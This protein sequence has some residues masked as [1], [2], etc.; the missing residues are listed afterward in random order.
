MRAGA[1]AARRADRLERQRD[2][3]GGRAPRQQ[4]LGVV[5]EHD[6]DVAAR[7]L[8]RRAGE[9]DLAAR[10]R[11]RG[12]R[13]RAA[14][15]S[16]RSPRGRRRRRSRRAASRARACRE[17]ADRRRRDRRR[18]NRSAARRRGHRRAPRVARIDVRQRR[19]DMRCRAGARPVRAARAIVEIGEP[20][21]LAQEFF[22]VGESR[23]H[24]SAVA[25]GL[26][27][28]LGMGGERRGEPQAAISAAWKRLVQGRRRRRR[29]RRS[30]GGSSRDIAL[31]LVQGGD[32]VA[33]PRRRRPLA[34][35]S[36]SASRS[37]TVRMRTMS[38][39]SSREIACD[40]KAAMA[41]R[42]DEA[43]RDEAR[44]RL[45]QRRR[46]DAVARRRLGD[47]EAAAGRERAGED[48][49]L[50]RA[51]A[52]SLRVSAERAAWFVTGRPAC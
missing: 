21:V 52:R 38:A 9:G 35:L 10:R 8:D 30:R 15:S 1:L 42:I 33:L 28:E 18:G 40:A 4:R 50:D 41:D 7:P 36:R 32:D 37:T 51:A 27:V 46:A 13:R 23:H 49:G 47:A 11:D 17:R 25:I 34:M 22:G 14:P 48:V 20:L 44:Q 39:R 16:C 45:A 3:A 12:R 6:G 5:L 43:A 26:V 29:L 31:Q 19:S 24:Q 2:I